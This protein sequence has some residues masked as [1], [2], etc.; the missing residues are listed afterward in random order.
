MTS[1]QTELNLFARRHEPDARREL[2]ERYDY[3]AQRL[4]LG[5]GLYDL[6]M[7]VVERHWRGVHDKG[8]VGRAGDNVER[9]ADASDAVEIAQRLPHAGQRIDAG[10]AGR[11]RAAWRR[12]GLR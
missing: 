8:I 10:D 9:L 5:V 6:G 4:A 2:V 11:P 3:L 1:S 7:G 12:Y